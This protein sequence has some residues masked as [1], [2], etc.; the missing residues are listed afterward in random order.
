[1]H[2]QNSTD[3]TNSTFEYDAWGAVTVTSGGTASL[4]YQLSGL[5]YRGYQYDYETGLYYVKSRY[6]NPRIGRFVSA[7]DPG[8]VGLS[9]GN[10]LGENLYAYCYNNPILN[11]DPSGYAVT[12]ANIIG[13]IVGAVLGAVGG[14]FLARWLADKFGLKKGVLRTVFIA[15]FAYV[16]ANIGGAIG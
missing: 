4:A 10:P 13:A 1:M 3:P 7:D 9:V 2:W 11:N 8:I 5:R 12:P 15:Q 6:Y 16:S 14:Y